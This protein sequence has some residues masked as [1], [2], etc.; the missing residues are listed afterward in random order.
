M[1][2]DIP[3]SK[4]PTRGQAEIPTDNSVHQQ[5]F[6]IKKI[7]FN[8]EKIPLPDGP[9]ISGLSW[10]FVAFKNPSSLLFGT[11]SKG[12][13]LV[14]NGSL[15]YC[16]MLGKE[17]EQVR[18]ITY[19]NHLNCYLLKSNYKM[20][21]K[22]IDEKPPYLY[23]DISCGF[24][25]GSA[26]RY[27]NFNQRVIMIQEFYNL[28]VVNLER[29]QVDI[30][31]KGK[32][33]VIIYDFLVFGTEENK[34]AYITKDN[35]IHLC[36]F[37]YDLKKI[38]GKDRHLIQTLDG[39]EELARA[40]GVCGQ[41]KYLLVSLQDDAATF[42]SSR[43]MVFA[44]ND[45]S[46]VNVATIDEQD[47]YH[48]EISAFGFLKYYGT[49]ALWAGLSIDCIRLFDFD[50]ESFEF[51]ELVEKRICNERDM[52]VFKSQ[53]IGNKFYFTGSFGKIKAINL[54][55]NLFRGFC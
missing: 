40:I 28:A 33:A 30:Q 16:K 6:D 12:I 10:T 13:V 34:L 26:F 53:T 35:S 44:A 25:P 50:T 15:L 49:H 42:E 11:Y 47:S 54:A 48:R 9:N 3:D 21:R 2:T 38:C 24:C 43:I 41:N 27:S 8:L 32:Q 18:E 4:S 5:E 22:D 31:V 39:S 55:F 23:M 37:N 45:H 17:A 46:L 52:S 1:E 36:T 14:E 19:I 51:R 20:Y 7:N 29:K